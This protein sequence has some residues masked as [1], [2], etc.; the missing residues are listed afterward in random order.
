MTF[1]AVSRYLTPPS[2]TLVLSP[3]QTL[4]FNEGVYTPIILSIGATQLTFSYQQGSGQAP[5]QQVVI[6]S[7]A[8]AAAFAATAL[9]NTADGQWLSVAPANGTTPATLT[10]TVASGLKAGTYTGL[11]SMVSN[12]AT[13]SPQSLSVALAVT[14]GPPP[15]LP[16]AALIFPVKTDAVH[17]GGACTPATVNITSV[18]DHQMDSAYESTPHLDCSQPQK[19]LPTYGKIMDFQGEELDGP[20]AGGTATP[21][22]TGYG[23]DGNLCG[24]GSASQLPLLSG[25]N[26]ATKL[27]LYYDGHPGYDY[28]FTFGTPVFPAVSGCVTYNL[29]AAGTGKNP[30]ATQTNYH[31]LTIIPMAQ[32][33]SSCVNASSDVGYT[34][35][36][37]HL[38]SFVGADGTIQRCKNEDGTNCVPCPECAQE[39]EWVD[40][41]RANPMAYVGNFDYGWQGVGSHLHFEV[42]EWN[43]NKPIPIDPYGWQPKTPGQPDPYSTIH[44]G[45]IN[46]LLWKFD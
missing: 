30:G 16:I 28:P 44:N 37:L 18:F 20:A 25:Y 27:Y 24:Y 15:P 17:C 32:A 5:S 10:V 8:P 38:S 22:T 14:K 1:G 3:G 21:S 19:A 29:N 34:V 33:P 26:L 41:S 43:H 4:V 40:L 6:S 2:Q 39:G 9:T 11:I 35:A 46:Q 23:Q 42:D 7:N 31:G 13:N 45:I 12:A 36:Y